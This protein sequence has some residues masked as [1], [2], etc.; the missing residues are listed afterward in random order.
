MVRNFAPSDIIYATGVKKI[1]ET[2]LIL[3]LKWPHVGLKLA[4]S[5]QPPLSV[6]LHFHA[7][8]YSLRLVSNRHSPRL[9]SLYAQEPIQG[10]G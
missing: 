4:L 9:R 8:S 7:H 5:G 2:S 6:L 3:H 1:R 10:I